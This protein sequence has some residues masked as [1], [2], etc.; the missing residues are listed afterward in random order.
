MGPKGRPSRERA[1]QVKARRLALVRAVEERPWSTMRELALAL[2]E[3][4]SVVSPDLHVLLV[5]GLVVRRDR[6]GRASGAHQEYAL[7]TDANRREA[8]HA[9]ASLLEPRRRES[10]SIAREAAGG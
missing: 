4:P 8:E 6:P 9:E 7:A 10:P 5:H 2:G 1:K 3:R